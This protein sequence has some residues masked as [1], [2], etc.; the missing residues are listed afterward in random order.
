MTIFLENERGVR[1][2]IYMLN[3]VQRTFTTLILKKTLST[4]CQRNL[5][6]SD[7]LLI[8]SVYLE[9]ERQNVLPQQ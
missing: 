8:M 2:L 3:G 6:R 1:F 4:V 5:T 9:I 7:N